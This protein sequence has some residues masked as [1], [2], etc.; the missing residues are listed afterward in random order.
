VVVVL[1]VMMEEEQVLD[2]VKVVVWWCG[3]GG[4]QKY[5]RW[6]SNPCLLP[7]PKVLPMG[8]EPCMP[9]TCLHVLHVQVMY[10]LRTWAH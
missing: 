5:F 1:V 9:L 3:E 6:G 4:G 10:K 7:A 8:F 2:E